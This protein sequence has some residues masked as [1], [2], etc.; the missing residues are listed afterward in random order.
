MG[1]VILLTVTPLIVGLQ[2]LTVRWACVD[3]IV[4][5]ATSTWRFPSMLLP[6]SLG[7]HNLAEE[8]LERVLER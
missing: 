2:G 5:I 3:V 6:A 8:H 1:L 7:T 4:L